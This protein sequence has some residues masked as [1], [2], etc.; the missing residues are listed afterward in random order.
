M[1]AHTA[2]TLATMTPSKAINFLKEGNQALTKKKTSKEK[3]FDNPL[4]S[5]HFIQA[6]YV[7]HCCGTK[8]DGPF[9]YNAET[10]LKP[11]KS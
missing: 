11:I 8:Q 6:T 3:H 4:H 2:E 5:C 1:K 9:T 10:K 7:L